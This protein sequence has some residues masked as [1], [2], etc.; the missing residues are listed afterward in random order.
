VFVEAS[1]KYP[2][3]GLMNDANASTVDS[4]RPV[5]AGLAALSES[6]S[7]ARFG[8]PPSALGQVVEAGPQCG[9]TSAELPYVFRILRPAHVPIISARLTGVNRR[10]IC[11]QIGNRFER[12]LKCQIYRLHT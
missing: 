3:A 5:R 2:V 11:Y 7:R 10:A 9:E 4:G 6:R 12:G 1:F 8:M